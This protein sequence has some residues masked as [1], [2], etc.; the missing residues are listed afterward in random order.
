M[1]NVIG[2]ALLIASLAL[3]GT[4]VFATDDGSAAVERVRVGSVRIEV[5]PVTDDQARLLINERKLREEARAKLD[6][7]YDA[8]LDNILASGN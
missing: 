6:A 3:S 7:D 4:A 5:I 8:A 1:K 2:K